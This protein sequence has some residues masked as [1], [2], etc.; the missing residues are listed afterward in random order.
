MPDLFS[1]W[2]VGARYLIRRTNEGSENTQ[3][4]RVILASRR[5][6][7]T[8]LIKYQDSV[9]YYCILRYVNS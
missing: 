5:Y 2:N 3:D 1:R 8:L 9:R 4:E 7:D 6:L